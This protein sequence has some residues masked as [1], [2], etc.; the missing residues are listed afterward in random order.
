M[1]IIAAVVVGA[2]VAE[3]VSA[4]FDEEPDTIATDA[5]REAARHRIPRRL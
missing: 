5:E 1:G 4:Q 3:V 2:L